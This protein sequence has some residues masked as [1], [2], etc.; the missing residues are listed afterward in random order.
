MKKYTLLLMLAVL[1]AG[2]GGNIFESFEDKKTKEGIDFKISRDVDAENWEDVL[3]NPNASAMEYSAAAMGLAG[4]DIEEVVNAL[5]NVDNSS[6]TSDLGPF[7][8]I[9]LNPEALDEL[10]LAKVKLQSELENNPNDPDLAYQLV[11]VSLVDAATQLAYG[12]QQIGGDISNGI[13]TGDAKALANDAD[14]INEIVGAVAEDVK[15]VLENVIDAGFSTDVTDEIN[16]IVLGDATTP[17]INYDGVGD[18]S[19]DDLT[20]YLANYESGA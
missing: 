15:N 5:S 1:I 8:D 9:P 4:F 18:V 19:A 6:S 7:A 13:A 12:V 17:G 20:N 3:N 16:N 11:M 10:A 2:C 14:V